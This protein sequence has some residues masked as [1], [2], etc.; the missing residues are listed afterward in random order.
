MAKTRSKCGV[1]SAI[2]ECPVPK[3]RVYGGL[4]LCLM[5]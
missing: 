3:T 2:G 1:T 5:T 4:Y